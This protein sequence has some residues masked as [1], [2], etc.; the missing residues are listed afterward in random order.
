MQKKKNEKFTDSQLSLEK[1]NDKNA[2]ILYLSI[3]IVS[4]ATKKKN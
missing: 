2:A 1:K 4:D 3:R